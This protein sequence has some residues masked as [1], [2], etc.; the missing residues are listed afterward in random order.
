MFP[1]RKQTKYISIDDESSPA[2]S[3]SL[4]C[5]TVERVCTIHSPLDVIVAPSSGRCNGFCHSP[6]PN[7]HTKAFDFILHGRRKPKTRHFVASI[8]GKCTTCIHKVR[9]GR[10]WGV[11]IV[12]RRKKEEGSPRG[13][14]A[15]PQRCELTSHWC[16]RKWCDPHSTQPQRQPRRPWWSRN[17]D[18]VETKRKSK[19]RWCETC[20]QRQSRENRQKSELSNLIWNFFDER[21][22][23][24]IWRGRFAN[25]VLFWLHHLASSS[26]AQTQDTRS[27]MHRDRAHA[28]QT[29]SIY[30]LSM[31]R[32]SEARAAR[33]REASEK[34]IKIEKLWSLASDLVDM[35]VWAPSERKYNI[36]CVLYFS[37]GKSQTRSE[38]KRWRAY[39]DRR[40]M[41]MDR[42]HSTADAVVL[43]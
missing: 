37:P 27:R 18:S 1:F 8:Q 36:F 5:V 40:K 12:S 3:C 23:E 29:S 42:Q 19:R 6:L 21:N 15:L 4:Q 30:L 39:C 43:H 33:E 41:K 10:A 13:W 17:G 38:R 20:C 26:V 7:V 9:I 16:Q 22:P 28:C 11:D 34:M 35:C 25:F 24:Y 2:I 32:D 31:T 14:A